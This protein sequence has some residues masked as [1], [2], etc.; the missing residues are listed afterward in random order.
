M[1]IYEENNCILYNNT[2]IYTSDYTG[3]HIINSNCSVWMKP[4]KTSDSVEI[5]IIVNGKVEVS[6][7]TKTGSTDYSEYPGSI[8]AAIPLRYGDKVQI[9]CK[10][11]REGYIGTDSSKNTLSI[12]KI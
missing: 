9:Y 12:T 6:K 3:T 11:N 5:Q 8:V 1:L 2:G 4:E 10:T 7:E